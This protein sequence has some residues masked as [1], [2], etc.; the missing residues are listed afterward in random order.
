MVVFDKSRY[1]EKKLKHKG[2]FLNRKDDEHGIFNNT[3]W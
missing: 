1:Y 2:K 3:A